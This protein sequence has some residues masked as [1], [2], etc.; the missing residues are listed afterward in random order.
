MKIIDRSAHQTRTPASLNG[1]SLEEKLLSVGAIAK[2]SGLDTTGTIFVYMD[3]DEERTFMDYYQ[4]T[5]WVK[6]FEKETFSPV[7]QD[8]GVALDSIV[9]KINNNHTNGWGR[10]VS[11]K[12]MEIASAPLG[13]K[14]LYGWIYI[15]VP[16]D[17]VWVGGH[18]Q[19]ILSR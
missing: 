3:E 2:E 12:G 11:C 5:F 13:A 19:F 15:P 4:Q 1:S 16:K 14:C 18:I 8:F 7:T 10:F 9:S 6:T 17:I